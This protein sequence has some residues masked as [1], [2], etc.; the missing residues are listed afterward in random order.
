[1]SARKMRLVVDNIR[2][3]EVGQALDILKFTRKEAG[4]WVEK[5]L[6][7][8][9]A[10]WKV[11]TGEEPDDYQLYVKAAYSDAGRILKRFMPA[12][13]GRAFRKRKRSN[14]VTIV[15]ANRAPLTE[16]V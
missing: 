6:T 12:P 9:I 11:K 5:L 14:H 4:V 16:E 15:V 10:N 2:G 7:S 13:H 3:K 1:M 8:A